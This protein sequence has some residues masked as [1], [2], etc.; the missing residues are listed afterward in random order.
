[1]ACSIRDDVQVKG[2]LEKLILEAQKPCHS[3]DPKSQANIPRAWKRLQQAW[4]SAVL[5]LHDNDAESFHGGLL[6]W[7]SFVR[8]QVHPSL[9]EAILREL[10]GHLWEK[11]CTKDG[12]PDLL[13]R[14]SR[15][16]K[17]ETASEP[18]SEPWLLYLYLGPYATP[19]PSHMR[20]LRA[21]L[22]AH[23]QIDGELLLSV[24]NCET[25]L[26]HL[27]WINRYPQSPRFSKLHPS[28]HYDICRAL[29]KLEKWLS[30]TNTGTQIGSAF[31]AY[32]SESDGNDSLPDSE[33][34]DDSDALSDASRDSGYTD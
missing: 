34:W 29:S 3:Q 16:L 4:W 32:N 10:Y 11:A 1:M 23:S 33:F 5:D 27:K 14:L 30:P 15:C 9:L 8:K 12:V 7:P 31:A 2:K 25:A 24:I 20:S 6:D 19:Y 26:R 17:I 22:N 28:W 18:A 21:W 13:I